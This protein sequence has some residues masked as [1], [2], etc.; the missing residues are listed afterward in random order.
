MNDL[1]CGDWFNE[2]VLKIPSLKKPFSE[3]RCKRTDFLTTDYGLILYYPSPY[4]RNRRVVI[5]AGCR[6]TGTEAA[7]AVMSSIK[8]SADLLLNVRNSKR[9]YAVVEI[10]STKNIE[11]QVRVVCPYK[12]YVIQNPEDTI[13]TITT[14]RKREAMPVSK[15]RQNMEANHPLFDRFNQRK[16]EKIVTM[17]DS[18]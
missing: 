2:H 16:L 14:I 4:N 7:V 13:D 10:I 17:L 18:I 11:H 8:Y 1:G 3:K 9:F 5:M 6:T 15:L 12:G